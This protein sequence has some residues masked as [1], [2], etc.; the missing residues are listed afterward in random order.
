MPA[1]RPHSTLTACAVLL[2]TSVGVARVAAALEEAAVTDAKGLPV[3]SL[4]PS[5]PKQSLADWL[6]GTAGPGA[7]LGWQVNSCGERVVDPEV[8]RETP[9]CVEATAAQ[10][11]GRTAHVLVQIGPSRKASGTRPV[12]RRA[13]V[14]AGGVERQVARL[15]GLTKLLEAGR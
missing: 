10:P 15:G 12:L 5:L 4:D 7:R 6:A 9:R 13:W 8:P 2:A 1:D 11:R 14:E 3:S